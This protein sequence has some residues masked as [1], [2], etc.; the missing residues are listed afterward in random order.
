MAKK[1]QE[2]N[3]SKRVKV[4]MLQDVANY[5]KGTV[6]EVGNLIAE[7]WVNS[8]VAK[9][10]DTSAEIRVVK[11]TIVALSGGEVDAK[12]IE[13]LNKVEEAN[14]KIADLTAQLQKLSANAEAAKQATGAAKA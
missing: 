13:A 1:E 2:V 6:V 5:G 3:L 8:K 7:K 4:E 12:V 11:P 10:A 14:T 9:L